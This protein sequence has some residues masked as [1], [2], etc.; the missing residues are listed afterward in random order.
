[1]IEEL[2]RFILVANVGN[3][4][5][6]AEKIFITQSALTQS[7]DRLEREIG[8]ELFVQK[9]RNME[10]TTD[11]KAL[12]TIGE[13]ILDLWEKAKD[14]LTRANALP[15][16]TIGMF[17]NAALR[18]AGF[19]QRHTPGQEFVLEFMID[20]SERLLSNLQLGVLD[21][22]ILVKSVSPFHKDIICLATFE[23]ELIPVAG[24]RFSGPLAEI[25]FVLYNRGSYSREQIDALFIKKGVKSKVYAESTS[26]HFMKELAILNTGVALLPENLVRQELKQK[27]LV[28]QHFKMKWTRE[29]GIFAQKNN[30]SEYRELL[31]EEIAKI[32]GE[33]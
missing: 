12:V 23:E 6:T 30:K 20:N 9:G 11:G 32:L 22:A 31:A 5:K 25:P 3:I 17:D 7:I 1:M 24:K 28:K 18:L 21:M 29:Y 10:L 8:S 26:V 15:T 19:V 14:P 27:I 13:K 33:K 2:R 4:T 16:L